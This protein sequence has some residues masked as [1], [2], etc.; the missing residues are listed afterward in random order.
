MHYTNGNLNVFLI[1]PSER[2]HY[3]ITALFENVMC[4]YSDQKNRFL[5]IYNEGKCMMA[6]GWVRSIYCQTNLSGYFTR[7]LFQYAV[8]LKGSYRVYMVN[9]SPES[10]FEYGSVIL[11]RII[12]N[13]YSEAFSPPSQ[14]FNEKSP[15]PKKKVIFFKDFYNAFYI[16]Y[17]CET[18]RLLGSYNESFLGISHNFWNHSSL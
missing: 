5:V 10:N 15:P 6:S 7:V 16:S 1:L 4:V 2:I 17:F 12:R 3:R 14:I 9:R 18:H 11:L 13:P 8:H